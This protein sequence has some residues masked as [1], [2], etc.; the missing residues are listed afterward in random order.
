MLKIKKHGPILA[1]TS[2]EFETRGVFNPAVYQDGKDVHIIYRA[3]NE[4]YNSSFGYAACKGPLDVVTRFHEPVYQGETEYEKKGIEDPRI[5]KIG[6]NFYMTYVA[7]DGHNALIAYMHGRNLLRLKRGGVISPQMRYFN[8]AEMFH[9]S[10]LKDDYFFFES[11]YKEYEGKGVKVWDKDGVFYPEKFG[12]RF[13]ML[14]RILPDMQVVF[15]RSFKELASNKFW[16]KHVK[17]LS[18]DVVLEGEHGFEAR[19][20][21]AGCPPV[22]TE[23][24]WLVI[25]HGVEESNKKRTYHANAVLYDLHE[26]HKMIAR[27]PEPMFSPTEDY[28]L[29]GHVNHVV[30]PTGTAQFDNKLYIY[31][32][33]ADK[34]VAVASCKTE[35]L[36][37][38]LR[39]NKIK[40]AK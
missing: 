18:K 36:L 17:N 39:K 34:Y 15:F 11:Y 37:K 38:L 32:G 31:Y 7:H 19:H 35:D 30:F 8:A 28:E 21:G 2:H 5:T 40:K 14:H 13:A 26:P 33:A 29:H 16:V 10:H 22:K 27:L 12:G 3:L 23:D 25:Y 20:V 9:E 4:T 6:N 1:P 24:G